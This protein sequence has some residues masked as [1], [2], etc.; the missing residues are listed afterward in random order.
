MDP[1][2]LQAWLV[3][4]PAPRNCT[5]RRHEGTCC[6]HYGGGLRAL[7]ERPVQIAG[8]CSTWVADAFASNESE[9]AAAWTRSQLLPFSL[10]SL[11]P[12]CVKYYIA[13]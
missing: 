3:A 13:Y 10:Q 9:R 11:K 2:A 1:A 4:T 7:E 6:S 8:A 5:T 12:R